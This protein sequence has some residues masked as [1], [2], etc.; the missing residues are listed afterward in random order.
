MHNRRKYGVEADHSPR[1]IKSASASSSTVDTLPIL[2]DEIWLMINGSAKLNPA[3][4]PGAMV[5]ENVQ[6]VMTPSDRPISSAI[7]ERKTGSDSGSRW[8]P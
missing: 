1:S 6:A 4:S 5:F 3:R 2:T 7:V 8:R